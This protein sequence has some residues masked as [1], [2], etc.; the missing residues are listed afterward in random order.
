MS[1]K[2][3]IHRDHYVT[4]LG[5]GG[6]QRN[7]LTIPNIDHDGESAEHLG[8]S[9]SVNGPNEYLAGSSADTFDFAENLDDVALTNRR[10]KIEL[11][12]KPGHKIGIGKREGS[13]V[14]RHF[15]RPLHQESAKQRPGVIQKLR[16]NQQSFLMPFACLWLAHNTV[17]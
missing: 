12:K 7:L 15:I 2:A 13:R 5:C 16:A 14:V 11:T 9:P 4:E 1:R 3:N 6:S 10:G 8:A 17:S